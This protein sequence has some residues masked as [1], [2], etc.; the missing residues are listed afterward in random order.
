MLGDISFEHPGWS[1]LPEVP[2]KSECAWTNNQG[3]IITL[4]HLGLDRA[5]RDR[6][7]EV[8]AVRDYYRASFGKRGMGLIECDILQLQGVPA[9]RAIAK[10]VLPQKGA[11]YAG[12]VALPL[13]KESYVFNTVAKELGITG[14]RETAVML[15]ISTEFEKQGYSLDLP[16]VS[17]Q[18][19][20]SAKVPIAWKNSATGAVIHWAQDPYEPEF[21]GPCLRNL[22]DSAEHDAGLPEHPLSRVRAALQSLTVG[23]TFS[24]KLQHRAAGRKRWLPW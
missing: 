17:G 21:K 10:L 1:L 20:E 11:A 18:Q 4:H 22:A 8:K 24:E 14:M 23:L 7:Q 16:A 12:T 3:L 5:L 15:K 2:A 19:S 9:V 13:P 6:M